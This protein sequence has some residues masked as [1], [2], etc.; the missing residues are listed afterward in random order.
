MESS[1]TAANDIYLACATFDY[2]YGSEIHTLGMERTKG[3]LLI[4]AEGIPDNIDFST[5]TIAGVFGLVD[6]GFAYSELTDVRTELDWTVRN[7]IQTQTLVCPSPSFEG[8]TLSIEFIDKSQAP[9]GRATLHPRSPQDVNITM[10]RNE[11]TILRYVY[12][13]QSG[14]GFDIY[15]RVNDNWELLHSM[16]ID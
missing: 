15:L 10:G 11:I 8:S 9:A 5:K 12:R 2:R 3:N 13:E 6:N 16:G 7:E 4:R 14:G 1:G